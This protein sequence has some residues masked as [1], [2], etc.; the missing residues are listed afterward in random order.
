MRQKQHG[1]PGPEQLTPPL[2]NWPVA[3][4]MKV[5]LLAVM[6][7]WLAVGLAWGLCCVP[8]GEVN[9]GY[10]RSSLLVVL[11][12]AALAALAGWRD[13]PI[14]LSTCRIAVGTLAYVGFFAWSV[15]WPRLAKL[16]T[17][18]TA[19]VGFVATTQ[20][21]IREEDPSMCLDVGNAIGG[22]AVLGA[23]MAAMLLGHYYL[24]AP[25]MSLKPIFRL[26]GGIVVAV[27]I[28]C[29]FVAQEAQALHALGLSTFEWSL[30]ATLRMGVGILAILVLTYMA[31]RTL[32]LKATQA[33]TGIL[34][35]VVIFAL[36]S[37]TT[38]VVFG[39]VAKRRQANSPGSESAGRP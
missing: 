35:V 12:L 7:T 9:P 13:A 27:A 14:A 15:D 32:K 4:L 28:R 25:W 2:A 29:V 31:V 37:E 23:T 20:L 16:A 24:T 22:S 38:G 5:M 11:G 34:Y 30:Y 1:D 39:E 3:Y 26:V 18:A 6:A 21:G 33:A 36:A 8:A 17:W 19:V 10:F